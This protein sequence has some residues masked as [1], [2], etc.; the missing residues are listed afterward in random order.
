MADG[1]GKVRLP[2]VV[3]GVTVEIACVTD[4]GDVGRSGQQAV[5]VRWGARRVGR[6]DGE[7][8]DDDVLDVRHGEVASL[9]S[10]EKGG[11]KPI[12]EVDD[13]CMAHEREHPYR[14]VACESRLKSFELETRRPRESVVQLRS[15]NVVHGG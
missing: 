8:V 4:E 12:G 15:S 9:D 3:G 5:V 14:L 7:T 13:G 2:A 10:G 1:R 6:F 11:A